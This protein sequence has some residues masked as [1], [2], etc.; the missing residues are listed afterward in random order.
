MLSEK[1]CLFANMAKEDGSTS[2]QLV[3]M[4]DGNNFDDFEFC[5]RT[6]L[7]AYDLENMLEEAPPENPTKTWRKNDAK[8][9]LLLLKN[10]DKK[11]LAEI[12][13]TTSMHEAWEKL[14]N[15]H[16]KT[17]IV[18]QLILR[19]KWQNVKYSESEPME[20]FLRNFSALAHELENTG[21]QLSESEKVNQLLLSLPEKY[22]SLINSFEAVDDEKLTFDFVKKRILATYQ[23]KAIVNTVDTNTTSDTGPTAFGVFRNYGRGGYPGRSSWRSNYNQSRSHGRSQGNSSQELNHEESNNERN[24]DKT[25]FRGKIRGNFRRNFRGNFSN[26]YR[27]KFNG[28]CNNCNIYGHKFSECRKRNCD[29][30]ENNNKANVAE[31]KN[32]S[33]GNIVDQGGNTPTESFYSWIANTCDN[34][35]FKSPLNFINFYLDSGATSHYVNDTKYFYEFINLKTPVNVSVFKKDI[36]VKATKIGKILCKV[37]NEKIVFSNVLYSEQFPTNL[38][39]VRRL[40][41]NGVSV[42]FDTD[43]KAKLLCNNKIVAVGTAEGPNLYK[44][45]FELCNEAE[46]SYFSNSTLDL[47]NKL[48]IW[49][50]RL[51]H[52]SF[53]VMEEMEKTGLINFD[54]VRELAVHCQSCVEGK[55]CKLPHVSKESTVTQILQ[56]VHSDV[57]GPM[58]TVSNLGMKY[59]VSFLDE[60]TSFVAV[61]LIKSKAE[62]LNKFK[63]FVARAENFLGKRVNELRC[64][65]GTEYINNAFKDYCRDKGIHIGASPPYCPQSN[66]RIERFNRTLIEKA[67]TLL[68][69]SG[70]PLKYWD[71][72]IL[73]ANFQY[74]RTLNSKNEVPAIC[75][76]GRDVDYL[77]FRIFGCEAYY[78]IPK[79]KGNEKFKQKTQKLIFVGYNPEG[80]RL[81]EPRTG[82][83]I[84][85][86]DVKF[87]EN[88]VGTDKNND[89]NFVEF[90]N[91]GKNCNCDAQDSNTMFDDDSVSQYAYFLMDNG[92]KDYEEAMNS[93]N[94]LEWKNSINEELGAIEINK[95]WEVVECPKNCKVLSTRWVF[96]VKNNG[97]FKARLVARGYEA[98]RDFDFSETYAPV[99][100][101]ST[102]RLLLSV[103]LNLKYVIKQVD[104][105]NA[106]LHS[107]LVEPVYIEIPDGYDVPNNSNVRSP[108]LLLRRALYGLKQ[109]S[110]QWNS[111]FD[112]FLISS[113]KFKRCNFDECLYFKK[114]NDDFVYVIVYVDDILIC[115]RN[116]SLVDELIGKLNNR[117]KCRI[118]GEPKSF[119][120]LEIDYR[121]DEGI[122]ILSQK[123]A[124]KKLKREYNIRDCFAY[125]P[126]EEKLYFDAS[127]LSE[128]VDVK[129]C[130]RKFKSLLGKLMYIMLGTRPD[131]SFGVSMFSQFQSRSTKTLYNYLFRVLKYLVSTSEMSLVYR[132]NSKG[133]EVFVDADWANCPDTR[134]SVSGFGVFV[135]GN[136]IAWKSKKQQI[137]TTSSTDSEIVAMCESAQAALILRNVLLEIEVPIERKICFYEDNQNCIRFCEGSSKKSKHVEVKYYFVRDLV[138]DGEIEVR[139][140]CSNEQVADIFTKGLGRVKFERFR[141]HLGLSK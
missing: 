65:N 107:A 66:G 78:L 109:A 7:A 118:L 43:Q 41:K 26:N 119:L 68:R 39:S 121:L 116:M 59:I 13:G 25:H 20:T 16:A 92:P 15:I 90:E 115:S 104:I 57:I 56:V 136:L 129:V 1:Y 54:R 11:Y 62:V 110:K 135:N 140:I 102:V 30:S 46:S 89:T 19:R 111:T 137:V 53:K 76:Y 64:D 113:L 21:T 106:F 33:E 50:R 91:D 63:E 74:N 82:K 95:V 123:S 96:R 125:T 23:R 70:L 35:K 67:R 94:A 100:K 28:R 114:I 17:G 131:L 120:G 84:I 5:F 77:K 3:H 73:C 71:E 83:I 45:S 8:A 130:Q 72:A 31:I 32:K 117:F 122:C 141:S 128:E 79:A 6:L 105:Q 85:A 61:Y 80:Y 69:D 58:R 22:E 12:K 133:I 14:H 37:G 4:F 29:Y 87:N 52:P 103:S 132:N 27:S 51:G 49:H 98:D 47:N 10:I 127:M 2:L 24:N 55:M 112:I 99:A 134:K 138:R 42:T 34:V 36:T 108:V 60:F 48:M 101:L 86:R 75:W 44:M 88:N 18:D 38:L 97:I 81:L 126:I 93:Q 124:I 9:R 139:S 40:V